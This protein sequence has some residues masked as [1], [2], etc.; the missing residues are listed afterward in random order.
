MS[1]A[2]LALFV[3]A[4]IAAALVDRGLW[5]GRTMERAWY[6]IHDDFQAVSRLTKPGRGRE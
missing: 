6:A 4:L 5:L 2:F 3:L 1:H